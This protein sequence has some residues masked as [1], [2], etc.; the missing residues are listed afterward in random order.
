M[1]E[2]HASTR[3][4]FISC[5]PIELNSSGA[6]GRKLRERGASARSCIQSFGKP[7]AEAP[8]GKRQSGKGGKQKRNA[9]TT[10]SV[11]LVTLQPPYFI[12][13]IKYNNIVHCARYSN[14]KIFVYSSRK[15]PSL[16]R[17]C[18]KSQF[19]VYFPRLYFKKLENF[20]DS[21]FVIYNQQ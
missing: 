8:G 18:N 15:F 3:G 11:H 16:Q 17:V 4:D 1:Q 12:T 5:V 21:S 14:V 13:Y 9:V 2:A 10:T 7:L 19:L 20:L 6:R